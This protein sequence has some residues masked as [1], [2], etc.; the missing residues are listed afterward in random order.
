MAVTASPPGHI[1]GS[2]E[3]FGFQECRVGVPELCVLLAKKH[4]LRFPAPLYYRAMSPARTLSWLLFSE[5]SSPLIFHVS[6]V[7]STLVTA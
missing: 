5:E 2:R 4:P 6:A 3:G 1:L 7:S